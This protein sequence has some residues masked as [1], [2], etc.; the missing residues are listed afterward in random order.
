M[1]IILILLCLTRVA[2]AQNPIESTNE[3]KITG[4]VKNE[5]TITLTDL[6]KYKSVTLENINTSCSPKESEMAIT[7]KAVLLKDIMDSIVFQ[8][9]NRGMLNAFYFTFVASD[10]YK[11][12]YSFNEIFNTET[13]NNLYIVTE[14]NGVDIRDME[15]RILLLTTNDIKNGRRNI[16][17][18]ARIIV[19]QAE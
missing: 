2:W 1:K 11:V 6:K 12:V 10:N 14:K 5:K 8:Y 3:F 15:N 4:K 7:V 19:N 13:G 9:E 18:L 16:K 17:G